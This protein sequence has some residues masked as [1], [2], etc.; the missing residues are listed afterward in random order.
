MGAEF[1]D[2]KQFSGVLHLFCLRTSILYVCPGVNKLGSRNLV[3]N[4]DVSI[5]VQHL[6]SDLTKSTKHSMPKD[7]FLTSPFKSTPQP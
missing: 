3:Q 1:L 7:A 4:K 2:I 5:L 6:G